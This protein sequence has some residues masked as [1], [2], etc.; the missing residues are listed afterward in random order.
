MHYAV[1]EKPPQENSTPK[2]HFLL[3]AHPQDVNLESKI[4]ALLHNP[5]LRQEFHAYLLVLGGHTNTDL[6][7]DWVTFALNQV[8]SLLIGICTDS[9]SG[10]GGLLTEEELEVVKKCQEIWF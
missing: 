7:R 8:H 1:K 6:K 2:L 9:S 4:T 10:S 5:E 3:T